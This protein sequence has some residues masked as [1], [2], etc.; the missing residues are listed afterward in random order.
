MFKEVQHRFMLH[1]PKLFYNG[2]E[3]VVPLKLLYI[4]FG[5][6]V[7]KCSNYRCCCCCI[8]LFRKKRCP[9]GNECNFLHAFRNPRNEYSFV[10]NDTPV[11]RSIYQLP[12]FL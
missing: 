10:D 1:L 2:V 11:H 3:A 7:L 8:G 12:E 9:K 5:V 4:T 6:S